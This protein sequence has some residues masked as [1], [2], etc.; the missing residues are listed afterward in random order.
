MLLTGSAWHDHAAAIAA[1][2]ALRQAILD[3]LLAYCLPAVAAAVC[4]ELQ[5]GLPARSVASRMLHT[6]PSV[7]QHPT[8]PPSGQERAAGAATA[9]EQAAALLC[10]IAAA[11]EQPN[12]MVGSAYISALTNAAA[13]LSLCCNLGT[14]SQQTAAGGSQEEIPAGGQAAAERNVAGWYVAALLPQLKTAVSALQHNLQQQQQQPS[15]EVKGGCR[16]RGHFL[17]PAEFAVNDVRP[18]AARLQPPAGVHVA[19]C[20]YCWAAAAALRCAAC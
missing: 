10:S 2:P 17:E 20:S 11:H 16:A 9:V 5:A 14:V 19:G 13:L 15:A 7:L 18:S 12:G 4:S 1:N 8:I 3:N 6:L